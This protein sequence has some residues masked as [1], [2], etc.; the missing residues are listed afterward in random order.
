MDRNN[1]ISY[2]RVVAMLLVVFG[3]AL[4]IYSSIVH[5]P[6]EKEVV[7]YWTDVSKVIYSVHMPVFFVISGFL[8]SHNFIFNNKYQDQKKFIIDKGKRVIIPYLVWVVVQ[9]IIFYR[10]L[11]DDTIYNGGFHLWFLLALFWQF[12][13]FST[14]KRLWVR[15]KVVLNGTIL[16]FILAAVKLGHIDMYMPKVLCLRQFVSFM[17]F[18]YFGLIMGSLPMGDMLA[19]KKDKLLVAPAMKTITGGAKY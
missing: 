15:N 5:W 9:A 4:G 13:F 2:M 12:V 17:P 16:L 7:W 3:H 10:Y 19:V 11:S 6:F 14:F 18:F 8:Y 1:A